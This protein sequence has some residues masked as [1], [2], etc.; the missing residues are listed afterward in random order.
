M[1]EYIAYEGEV[2]QIEWYYNARGESQAF[3]YLEGLSEKEQAKLFILLERMGDIG[4]IHNIEKFRN[5]GDKIFAFKPQPHRFLCFFQEGKKIII[6]NAFQKK[7][8]KLPR[9]QKDTALKAKQDYY[10][11]VEKGIYYEDNEQ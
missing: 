1:R 7:Q 6:T 2:F 3:T 8:Q 4:K 9:N 10:S 11:R 5:E